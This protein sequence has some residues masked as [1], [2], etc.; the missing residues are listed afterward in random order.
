MLNRALS[1]QI[2]RL[3]LQEKKTLAMKVHKIYPNFSDYFL[4]KSPFELL[5]NRRTN[6]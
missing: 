3:G 6:V 2:L 4:G 5:F 1:W